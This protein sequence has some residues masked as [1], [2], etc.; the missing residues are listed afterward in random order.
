MSAK[1]VATP[2][3]PTQ[4]ARSSTRAAVSCVRCSAVASRWAQPRCSGVRVRM[5]T[6]CAWLNSLPL[7]RHCAALR[8]AAVTPR[9]FARRLWRRA[10]RAA[11]AARRHA[12][13]RASTFAVVAARSWRACNGCARGRH[14]WFAGAADAAPPALALVVAGRALRAT[15]ASSARA[16]PQLQLL[17][18]RAHL[19]GGTRAPRLAGLAPDAC[20]LRGRFRALLQTIPRLLPCVD[21]G[22][23]S[24]RCS[25]RH[26]HACASR[27]RLAGHAAASQLSRMRCLC[28]WELERGARWRSVPHVSHAAAVGPIRRLLRRPFLRQTTR[29]LE[30]GASSSRQQMQQQRGTL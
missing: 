28:C 7:L 19:C 6:R 13:H 22:C 4:Q 25:A 16:S 5:R 12:W 24:P 29:R 30:E 20:A 8:A 27:A 26:C 3:P 17:A 15:L 18:A 1:T 21:L 14:A 11:A 9:R 10:P 23:T 2:P